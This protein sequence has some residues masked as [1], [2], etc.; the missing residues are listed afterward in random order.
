MT[1]SEKWNLGEW[2]VAADGTSVGDIFEQ[3]PRRTFCEEDFERCLEKQ[4]KLHRRCQ[5]NYLKRETVEKS[6]MTA[7]ARRTKTAQRRKQTSVQTD[8]L[9]C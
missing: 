2:E 1:I 8:G 4:K 9:G 6:P 5:Q 3:S 7:K